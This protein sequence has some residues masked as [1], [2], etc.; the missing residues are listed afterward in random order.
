MS[1]YTFEDYD[2]YTMVCLELVGVGIT[3]TSILIIYNIF[4]KKTIDFIIKT[5]YSY[6]I[7]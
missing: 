3:V 6:Y 4:F 7:D 2:L 1:T 5:S